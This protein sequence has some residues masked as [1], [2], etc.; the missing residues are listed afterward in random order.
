MQFFYI[1][2]EII[3]D[4]AGSSWLDMQMTNTKPRWLAYR[5]E[6]LKKILFYLREVS[7]LVSEM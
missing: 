3:I 5:I 6:F 2:F 4:R 1:D 7:S